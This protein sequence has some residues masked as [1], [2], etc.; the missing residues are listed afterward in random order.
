[1]AA[2]SGMVGDRRLPA[3]E[4]PK[5]DLLA[6]VCRWMQK[7]LQKPRVGVLGV[8]EFWFG[9]AKVKDLKCVR[10][11]IFQRGFLLA[12]QSADPFLLPSPGLKQGRSALSVY[13]YTVRY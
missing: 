3:P 13:R 4:A 12:F 11:T 1:M 6:G 9:F 2:L 5:G 7:T 8:W 10:Q